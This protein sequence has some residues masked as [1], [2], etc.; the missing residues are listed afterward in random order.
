MSAERTTTFSCSSAREIA[1]ALGCHKISEKGWLAHCLVHDD[2]SPSLSIVD[3]ECGRPIVQCFAGC[4]F[5]DVRDVLQSVGSCPAFNRQTLRRPPM[6]LTLEEYAIKKKF[7]RTFLE[8]LGIR[9]DKG[10]ARRHPTPTLDVRQIH[11]SFGHG[12]RL[13]VETAA[14]IFG[15]HHRHDGP[16][17]V[18]CL[19]QGS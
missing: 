9:E 17:T 3:D 2:A 8:Q 7:P 11:H 16:R 15:H 1:R 10:Q 12:R 14:A 13:R 18:G 19:S 5:R 6:S 4:D